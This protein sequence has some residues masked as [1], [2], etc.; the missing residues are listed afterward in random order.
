MPGLGRVYTLD[1]KLKD[2]DVG[3]RVYQVRQGKLF[4][5]AEGLAGYDSVLQRGLRSLIAD[6]AVKGDVSIATTGMGDPSAFAR[7]QAGTMDPTH[8]LAEAY[9]RNNAGELCGSRRI[10]RC[11]QLRAATRR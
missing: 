11:G 4:Y 1:C 5:S 9:R 2:A 7:V 8:A 10:L 3:Y 6:Q